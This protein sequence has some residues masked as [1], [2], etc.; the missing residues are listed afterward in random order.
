MPYCELYYHIVWATKNR[1][2][3]ISAN[4][5]P[6]IFSAIRRKALGLGMRVIA[7]NGFS[8]HVHLVASVPSKV[9]I[10]N[11]V[12]ELKGYSSFRTNHSL[13]EFPSFYWQ[14]EYGAF[15][16]DQSSISACV[17]YVENQKKHHSQNTG[18]IGAWESC[19][20][21]ISPAKPGF[22]A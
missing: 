4:I 13:P 21:E 9:S 16:L 6:N 11:V 12:G 15:T 3:I 7:I 22:S 18:I 8:D 19:G 20:T 5:E 2:P 14:E 17:Q 1:L 10:A